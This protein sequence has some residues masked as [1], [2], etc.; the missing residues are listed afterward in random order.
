MKTIYACI[1]ESNAS[2]EEFDKRVPRV[3]AWLNDL[4]Q[5]GKLRGCGGC[6][7]DL[8]GGLTLI[9]A[10]SIEEVKKM[11]RTYPLNE[12][13]KTKIVPW[14]VYHCD[15]SVEGKWDGWWKAKAPQA[16]SQR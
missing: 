10:E 7:D 5:S 11:N 8:V 6:Q 15:L 3:M 4:K 9:E 13:G 16:G 14:D 1:W 2:Q 12:I